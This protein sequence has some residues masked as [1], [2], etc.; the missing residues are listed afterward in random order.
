[1]IA[2]RYRTLIARPLLIAAEWGCHMPGQPAAFVSYARFN[3]QHDDGWVSK[4]CKLL[5]AEVQVQRGEEFSIFQDRKDIAWGQSWQKRID[6]TL[7]AVTLLLVIITPGFFR[8]SACRAEV[9]RFLARER[10]LDR[11]DLILPV[12]YVST[13]ELEDLERRDADELARVLAS[14]QFEDWRSLRFEPLTS[15]KARKAIADLASRMRDTFW[16]SAANPPSGHR[17]LPEQSPP[18]GDT[19]PVKINAKTDPQAQVAGPPVAEGRSKASKDDGRAVKQAVRGP[20]ARGQKIELVYEVLI[21]VFDYAEL[22]KFLFFRF[23]RNLRDIA[24]GSANFADTCFRVVRKSDSE[25]WLE[26]LVRELASYRP[27]DEMLRQLP[28]ELGLG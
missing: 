14:R 2:A 7:D 12:Y 23:D 22:D 17:E 3:D 24:V 16:R 5:S 13:P 9:E 1:L 15:R 21:G 19:P 10:D 8:S 20:M 26:R 6:Q 28:N 4:F 25:G 11:D 18:A 27:G